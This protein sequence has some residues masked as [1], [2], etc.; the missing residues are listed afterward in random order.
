M[1]TTSGITPLFPF[2]TEEREYPYHFLYVNGKALLSLLS[3]LILEK[4]SIIIQRSSLERFS[5]ECR[6]TKTKVITLASH[7]E[8]RQYSEPIE[9]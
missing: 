6:K 8:Q 1:Y 5:L 9:T 4:H 3:L 2:G 7:K